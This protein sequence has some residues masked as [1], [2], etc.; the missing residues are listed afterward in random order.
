MAG[1]VDVFLTDM[2]YLSSELSARYSSA[3]DYFE[4][5]I[6]SLEKMLEIAPECVFDKDGMLTCGVIVRHL[7]LPS[8]RDD[9]IALLDE[10]A[11]RI[12]ISKIKLSL[13]SQYTPDFYK[14]EDKALKRRITTFEY[15]SVVDRAVALGYDGYIQDR[16]S[17]N[18]NYTPEF[19]EKK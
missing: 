2:K 1:Y 16:E 3:R 9:S 19:K 6:S 10:L 11:K 15:Q 14:G 5:A 17:A 18:K 8:H 12:D 7:V 13:M 4:M